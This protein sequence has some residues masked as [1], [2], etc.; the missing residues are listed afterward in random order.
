MGRGVYKIIS[1]YGDL[2]TL[3]FQADQHY[4]SV[5]R[6]VSDEDDGELQGLD[7]T[8]VAKVKRV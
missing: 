2:H 7:P 5:N 3:T 8:D 6:E 1:L 4:L